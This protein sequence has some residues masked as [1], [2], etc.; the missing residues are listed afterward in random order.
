MS[1]VLEM[2][3]G[4]SIQDSFN[5]GVKSALKAF[6]EKQSVKDRI[7]SL[8]NATF[9]TLFVATSLITFP[10]SLTHRL[11]III[12]KPNDTLSFEEALNLLE[13]DKALNQANFAEEIYVSICSFKDSCKKN[14][15][16]EK[17]I[18]NRCKVSSLALVKEL[19][20]PLSSLAYSITLFAFGVL[21]AIGSIF[22]PKYDANK[23]LYMVSSIQSLACPISELIFL[24]ASVIFK[25]A[26]ANKAI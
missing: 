20:R 8:Q 22:S 5:D 18:K 19:A 1:I 4:L 9:F 14:L 25:L 11:F 12:N 10:L 7:H 16:K 3:R 13:D 23:G 21:H 26:K 2:S 6:E 17:G 24:P 15:K